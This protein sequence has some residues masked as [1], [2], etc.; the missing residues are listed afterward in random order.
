MTEPERALQVITKPVTRALM[1]LPPDFHAPSMQLAQRFAPLG[2]AVVAAAVAP[3]RVAFRAIDLA[4]LLHRRPLRHGHDP[5]RLDDPEALD[6]FLRGAPDADLEGV[7]EELLAYLEPHRR[8]CDV[9]ALSV[10]RGS[11]VPVAALLGREIKRRWGVRLIAG[12]VSP[13]RLRAV[14]ERAGAPAIDVITRASTPAQLRAVFAALL[15]LPRDRAGPPLDPN[16]D[17]IELIRGGMRKAPSSAGWP[18]P[19]FGIYD[20]DLYRRPLLDDAMGGAHPEARAAE[21]HLVLPYHFAF[22]CQFSCAFCQTGGNQEAKPID[23]VVRELATLAERWGTRDFLFFNAQSNLL[24]PALSRSLLDAKLD[25]RWSDSYRVRPRDPGDLELMARAGCA[26]LTVGVESAS[27]RVLKAM[28]KGHRADQASEMIREAHACEILLR[29]NILTC[30]PGET[31][32]DLE[33]TCRWVEE[34]A[35]CID[36]LAPSS[37]YLTADSPL[38]RH[39]ERY[40]IVVRGARELR[41]PTKFRKA[42]DSLTYDEI[43]GLRWEEREPL[44]AESEERVRRAYARGRAAVDRPSAMAPSTMLGLRRRFA[45]KSELYTAIRRWQAAPAIDV[46]RSPPAIAPEPSDRVRLGASSLFVKPIGVGTWAWGE[47]EYWGYERSFGAR[48]VVDAFST[49]VDLGLDFFDTAEVYGHGESEKILGWM[50]RKRGAPLVVAT[51]F[52]LLPGR[53][54]ARALPRALDASL[55]RLGAPR[56]DLYQIHWADV[57]MASIESLMDAMADA[58][59][60]GKIAA[61]GVSN[62]S[63]SEMRAAHAALA[64]RGVPL[65]TNQVHYSLLHRAPE[66]DGVLDACRDLG[67]TLLAYSPLEQ[68][69]LTG[70]YGPDRAP[71]GPRARLPSFAAD[72]LRALPPVL[73]AL[74]AV[75]EAHGGTRPEQVALAWL[76]AKPNVV[77]IPGA[78]DGAQA[79]INAGALA[80]SLAADEVERLDRAAEAWKRR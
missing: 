40:G 41:G 73:D 13:D 74:R 59:A 22:E 30:F 42:P 19:D 67:V 49:S 17:V 50:V 71:A 46:T 76:R 54:G 62:F 43:G 63:A 58:V 8:E 38:G 6:A 12:G 20:L 32:D 33:E 47:R 31:D 44:L 72:N 26:G 9:V 24:A 78:K 65:A 7:A 1:V 57:A 28:I 29:V 45:K 56:V 75:G 39:P 25:L 53:A 5:A 48:E 11:Q 64:R 61:V 21:P 16:P 10:D 27:D 77:P 15:D 66:I 37:F 35:A 68:G 36:D 60:A 2:P 34:H 3:L 79:A 18:M 55:R 69:L 52:A 51:K 14:I 23:Q 70:K 80:L 4:A